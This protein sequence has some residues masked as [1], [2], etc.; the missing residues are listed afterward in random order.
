MLKKYFG[1]VVI[2]VFTTSLYAQNMNITWQKVIG[3][4]GGESVRSIVACPNNSGYY[5]LGGSN[6]NASGDK[7]ENSRGGVDL[8]LVK[9][10]LDGEI[11]WEKTIGGSG[12]D[13][14]LDA[15]IVNDTLFLLSRSSSDVSGDKTSPN[16]GSSDIWLLAL[17]LDGT[18]LYQQSYGGSNIEFPQKLTYL[19]GNSLLISSESSSGI[20]G[21]KTLPLKG[22]SDV[23]ILEID[24]RNGT[25]LNQFSY[26]TSDFDEVSRV[27]KDNNGNIYIMAASY[28][29]NLDKT[30]I[31]NGGTDI[32]IIKLDENFN[33]LDQKCFGGSNS[34]Y[35]SESD[36][37]V[38]GE[39]IYFVCSSQSD[40]SG[41]KTAPL[42]ASNSTMRDYW[43]V[44][45]DLNLNIVWD[46]SFGGSNTDRSYVLQKSFDKIVIGGFS[47]SAKDTG[48]KTAMR[49]GESD[50]WLVIVD[51]NGN[52]VAQQSYGGSSFDS[53][54]SFIQDGEGNLIIGGTSESPI[55]GNKTL[56]SKGDADYWLLKINAI[57]PLGTSNF[58]K[59]KTIISAFPNPTSG[60]IEFM[61]NHI[62]N[63]IDVIDIMGKTV[64]SHEPNT[65]REKLNLSHLSSGIYFANII[66]EQGNSVVKFV[67]E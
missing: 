19:K 64:F 21:N 51:E 42:H 17:D 40:I 23:W 49:Y 27:I 63:R 6:S 43:L 12:G 30:A 10:D 59:A 2:A 33:E 1:I 32:W 39:Y 13:N 50:I 47:R 14:A 24:K 28:G 44:K 25:I 18:I 67:V 35:G 38:D 53:C 54:V 5:L 45:L 11:E 4:S 31:G 65:T 62:M 46:R 66:T 16:F 57:Q 52:E 29:S 60:G 34:E 41:N 48:T 58:S 56:A 7:S 3:G 15:L 22:G 20:D 8:W 61:S 37:L 55:S 26:G 36:I 9:T